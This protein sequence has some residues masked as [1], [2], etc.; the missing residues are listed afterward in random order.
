M[1]ENM[2]SRLRQLPQIVIDGALALS[3]TLIGCALLALLPF[4]PRRDGGLSRPLPASVEASHPIEAGP[5]GPS[6]SAS[7]WAYV[8]TAAAFLP[9]TLRHRFPVTVLV[10]TSIAATVY[11]MGH[12]PPSIAFIAPWWLSTR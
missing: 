9:L 8:V 12:F 7:P 5:F 1:V 4:G 3:A 10:A 11:E 6:G 2:T